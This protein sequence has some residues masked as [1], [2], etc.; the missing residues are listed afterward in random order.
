MW[1]EKGAAEN[2]RV[3]RAKGRPGS[4]EKGQLQGLVELARVDCVKGA[5]KAFF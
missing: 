3:G 2:L 4:L 1:I 5:F